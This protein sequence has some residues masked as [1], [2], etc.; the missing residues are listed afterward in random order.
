MGRTPKDLTDN[1][2][3]R[4]T[5]QNRIDTLIA[6]YLMK[7]ALANEKTEAKRLELAQER[8][9]K[10]VNIVISNA[11]CPRVNGIYSP[12]SQE[13]G[14]WPVYSKIGDRD[15]FLLY[16]YPE[17][18]IQSTE[19]RFKDLESRTS[20][21][22]TKRISRA[23]VRIPCD[24]ANYPELRVEGRLGVEE[25]TE[26]MGSLYLSSQVSNITIITELESQALRAN[27]MMKLAE[28]APVSPVKSTNQVAKSVPEPEPE[29]VNQ[30][31]NTNQIAEPEPEPEPESLDKNTN[32]IAG[33]VPEP[34]NQ[35][36]NTDQVA[37][38]VLEP[39]PEPET[40]TE[41]PDKNTNQIAESESSESNPDD[42]NTINQS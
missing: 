8:Y 3:I 36:K 5:I 25:S 19:D 18:L 27:E 39:E 42:T 9:R 6:E 33:L 17:W 2:E 29:P 10:A 23:Y 20:G 30:V 22:G 38:S 15:L 41:S 24:P 11:L 31:K 34:V 14:D 12:I 21:E 7:E 1:D 16:V 13:S 37:K 4:F 35:V 26:F 28:S 40:E 32:Q